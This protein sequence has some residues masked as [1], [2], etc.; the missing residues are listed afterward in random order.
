MFSAASAAAWDASA[1]ERAAAAPH[2]SP[3]GGYDVSLRV[4]R[5]GSIFDDVGTA[6]APRSRSPSYSD[7][8]GGGG[9]GKC[10]SCGNGKGSRVDNGKGSRLGGGMGSIFGGTYTGAAAETPPPLPPYQNAEA[11][12]TVML[13]KAQ[14]ENQC[15]K[16]RVQEYSTQIT[17]LQTVIEQQLAL[18][19]QKTEQIHR[20]QL[21]LS[22]TTTALDEAV[23]EGDEYKTCLAISEERFTELSAAYDRLVVDM[24]FLRELNLRMGT[25]LLEQP[26]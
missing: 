23:E 2:P 15:L 14:W 22:A 13:N 5:A 19:V 9:K 3:S 1:A 8:S 17:G 7:S 18:A 10:G 20:L 11:E 21:D 24:Q 26:F 12:L 6:P 4:V 25:S 16:T